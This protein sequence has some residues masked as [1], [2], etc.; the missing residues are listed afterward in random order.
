MFS[1]LGVKNP[2]ERQRKKARDQAEPRGAPLGEARGRTVVGGT[3][4]RLRRKQARHQ[5]VGG[6]NGTVLPGVW[7]SS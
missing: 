3:D 5:G 7:S 6:E 1:L 2:P 4:A